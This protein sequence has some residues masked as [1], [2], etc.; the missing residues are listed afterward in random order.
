MAGAKVPEFGSLEELCAEE[1]L[2]AARVRYGRI[3]DAFEAKFDALPEVYGRSP[4]RVNL[5]GEHIDYEGYGVL[6]MAIAHDTVVAIRRGGSDLHIANLDGSRFQDIHFS[7]DPAQKVDRSHHTWANYIMCAYK[8]VFEHLAAKRITVDPVGLQLMVHGTVPTGA[9][10]SSSSALVC[11][12]CLAL[13]GVFGISLTKT[14]VA[15]FACSCE[16]Y[17]GTHSGGMDQAISIMGERGLAKKVDFNP[18]R[19]ADVHL[20]RG[21]TF[22]I[23]NSMAESNKAETADA[24]YNLR[25]TECRLAAA[26][27]AVALGLPAAK[28]REVTTLQQVEELMASRPDALDDPAGLDCCLRRGVKFVEAQLH[29]EPYTQ[30]ELEEILGVKLEDLLSDSLGLLTVAAKH[31]G[32]QLRKRASHVFAEAGRVREFASLCAESAGSPR[33]DELLQALGGLMNDSHR[34][35]S[36]LYECS[37]PELEELV[38]ICR[39]AG[40]IGA[41]LTGAGWGG[42][43]VSMVREDGVERFVAALKERYYG[44]AMAAGRINAAGAEGAIFVS[45]PSPGGAIL[46]LPASQA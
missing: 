9:G 5:I 33:P 7:V 14:E 6:P 26:C 41:R 35:C 20:P 36:Q 18:I 29:E 15:D 3:R 44:P 43:T 31:G 8:G 37:C 23:A 39:E 25:V 12:T 30:A 34:S 16:R 28:A 17:V 38:P 21:V 22:V 45:K 19:T 27:L 11:S 4:G 42:C 46:R 32:F 10:V 2:G 40:A 13:L 1:E 24:H